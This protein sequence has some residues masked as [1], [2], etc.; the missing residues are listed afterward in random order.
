MHAI[1]QEGLT[2]WDT[3]V[4]LNRDDI[5]ELLASNVSLDCIY[6]HW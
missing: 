3:A 4:K 6:T 1:L 2:V 5:V